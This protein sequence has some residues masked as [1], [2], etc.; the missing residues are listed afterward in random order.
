[1]IFTF[2]AKYNVY[3]CFI[4]TPYRHES[5]EIFESQVDRI[6]HSKELRRL[7]AVFRD[8]IFYFKGIIYI[9]KNSFT[10]IVV[11]NSI[12]ETRNIFDF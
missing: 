11:I 4:S 3:L 9:H 1:M 8:C 10:Y 12:F 5:P 7:C 6:L 2:N